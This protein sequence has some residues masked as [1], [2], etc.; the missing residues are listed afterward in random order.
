MQVLLLLFAEFLYPF[1]SD[2]RNF[3]HEFTGH[4]CQWN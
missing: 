1:L 4:Q 2:R 3:E